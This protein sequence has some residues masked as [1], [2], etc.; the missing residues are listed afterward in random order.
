MVRKNLI[1]KTI[2]FNDSTFEETEGAN[3][4]VGFQSDGQIDTDSSFKISSMYGGSVLMQ[5][6]RVNN[7]NSLN[8]RMKN[9]NKETLNNLVR[10]VF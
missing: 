7:A 4:L 8:P 9:K 1:H 3:N 5:S 2:K 10:T 6:H